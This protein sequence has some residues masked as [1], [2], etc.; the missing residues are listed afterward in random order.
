MLQAI[1]Q[2]KKGFKI[3]YFKYKNIFSTRPCLSYNFKFIKCS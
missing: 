1:I 2:L 3:S